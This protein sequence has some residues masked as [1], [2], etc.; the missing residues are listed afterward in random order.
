M[1]SNLKNKAKIIIALVGLPGS[2]KT[3]AV[4][5]LLKKKL[6]SVRFGQIVDDFIDKHG[7]KHDKETHKKI[8][9]GLR[10]K[11]GNNAFAILN[12]KKIKKIIK[13]K[14]VLIDGLRSWEEYLYLKK[15]FPQVR[16]NIVLI[17]A[18]KKKR[19][20][21]SAKRKY[22]PNLFGEDRDI[23]ELIGMNMGPTIAMADYLVVNNS[24]VNRFYKRLDEIYNKVRFEL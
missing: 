6:S 4:K 23:N 11:F 14:S 10:K 17:Y 3:T 5:Y 20:Q 18:D 22:R 9:T 13:N 8:W 16:I 21:R 1:K 12:E 2:G 15:K 24:S 19:Y 7:F